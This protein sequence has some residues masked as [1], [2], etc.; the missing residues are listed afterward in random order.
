MML[1]ELNISSLIVEIEV[2]DL[3]SENNISIELRKE[4]EKDKIVIPEIK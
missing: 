1:F 3:A 4:K 2:T